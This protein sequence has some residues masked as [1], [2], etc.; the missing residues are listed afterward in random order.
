MGFWV[1]EKEEKFGFPKLILM[2]LDPDP[3]KS[4]VTLSPFG[5]PGAARVDD[6]HRRRLNDRSG[7]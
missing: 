1:G 4:W 3:G 6:I 2:K 7:F 5:A